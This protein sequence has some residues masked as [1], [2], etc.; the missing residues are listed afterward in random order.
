[1]ESLEIKLSDYGLEPYGEQ[2]CEDKLDYMAPE[3]V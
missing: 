3:S 2:D 1:M